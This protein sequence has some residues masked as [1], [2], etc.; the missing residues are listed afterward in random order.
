MTRV[1]WL[2][3]KPEE[4]NS[5]QNWKRWRPPEIN[6]NIYGGARVL[7]AKRPSFSQ[8]PPLTSWNTDATWLTTILFTHHT[9][10]GSRRPVFRSRCLC[11]VLYASSGKERPARGGALGGLPTPCPGA[12]QGG[13]GEKETGFRA[14]PPRV[15]QRGRTPVICQAR[16]R[17]SILAHYWWEP[18][19]TEGFPTQSL[20]CLAHARA[21][22]HTGA[23][24]P[25]QPP[26][27][28]VG[29][30][31]RCLPFPWKVLSSW[32]QR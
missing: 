1:K 20:P 7:P 14:S 12:R 21:H 24:T 6:N 25:S 17:A 11:P 31:G 2:S 13:T 30:A 3:K 28:P 26:T 15:G 8:S 32:I 16:P 5:E 27:G 19:G 18:R 9:P 22:I 10:L 23:R 29:I 4:R